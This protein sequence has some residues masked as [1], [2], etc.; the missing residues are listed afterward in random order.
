MI[1]GGRA[2]GIYKFVKEILHITTTE[3]HPVPVYTT[4][5]HVAIDF[6]GCISPISLSG[7][8]YA[9]IHVGDVECVFNLCVCVCVCV[10]VCVCVCVCI[11][12]ADACCN[13]SVYAAFMHYNDTLMRQCYI[14]FL[15]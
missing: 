1:M 14:T 4:L 2:L 13:L 3:L 12:L 11:T 10:F 6:I 15:H 7:N 9:H 5:H 8:R